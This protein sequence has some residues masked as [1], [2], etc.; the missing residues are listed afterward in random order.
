MKNINKL[1]AITIA[2][3]III[4]LTILASSCYEPPVKNKIKQNRFRYKS[5]YRKNDNLAK[6]L[7][8]SPFFY[9]S[10]I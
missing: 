4:F 10:L 8:V 9:L 7:S 2:I 5:K 1:S 6:G 3:F